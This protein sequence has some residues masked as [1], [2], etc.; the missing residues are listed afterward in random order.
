MRIL[1]L[2]HEFPPVGGGG[3]RVALDIARGL[4][5]LGHD[6]V[7]ITAHYQDLLLEEWIEGVRVIR[8]P[9]FRRQAFKAGLITMGAFILSGSWSALRWVNKL[10]PDLVHVH[11]AVPAGAIAWLLHRLRHTPYLLT[12][13]LGDVPGGVPEKTGGWF[14]WF[15]P[16][17]PPIWKNAARVVAVGEY[18]RQLALA[19]YPVDIQV[20]PNGV[21]LS[22][23]DPRE[24]R[25]GTPPRIVFAGRFV[26]Q[27]NPMQV[28]HTLSQLRE[29]D[30]QCVMIGD[31]PLYQEIESKRNQMGLQERV[32]LT[33]WV[34]P[35]E[36]VA[37]YRKSDILFM[38]SLSEGFPVV[39]VQSLAMGLAFVVSQIGGWLDLVQHNE[40]GFLVE[41]GSGEN[42]A[43]YLRNLLTSPQLLLEFRRASRQKAHQ[44]DLAA[45]VNRYANL[46]QR[47]IS[48]P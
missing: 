48:T 29:L 27:K 36:V 5:G 22:D 30:W 14:R 4:A 32:E 9:S 31:G 34:K 40:N 18:T 1:V 16:L 6:V 7:V 42:Y 37:W 28:I 45:V 39:G 21:D 33:G 23:L 44:F 35:E 25:L 24:I 43:N 12:V 2:I 8:V 38:P 47:I 19:H 11:F 3:G 15:Y 10:R 17:T 13:H 20:I 26:P 41:T 46:F